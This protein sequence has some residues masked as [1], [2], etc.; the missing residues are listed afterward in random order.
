M[1]EIDRQQF[2]AA[3]DAVP[4]GL[5]PADSKPMYRYHPRSGAA[6]LTT[7]SGHYLPWPTGVSWP[8]TQWPGGCGSHCPDDEAAF[9]YDFGITYGRA[10]WASKTGTVAYVVDHNAA[11]PLSWNPD[12]GYYCSAPGSP[13]NYVVINHSEGAS[14]YL[15][16]KQYSVPDGLVP[17]VTWRRGNRVGESG[18]VG[19]VC[20]STNTPTSGAHLHYQV[21]EH[22]IWWEQ[23]SSVDF[24]DWNETSANPVSANTPEPD[25]TCSAPT[26]APNSLRGSRSSVTSASP[27]NPKAMWLR[28]WPPGR[29]SWC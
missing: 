6:D 9:A 21:Q 12:W 5:L 19:Y 15:H 13:A 23:S 4:V 3:L 26:F 14:L 2:N 25:P 17:G 16:L 8:V 18:N 29:R 20:S 24:A 10:I 7:Y 28:G 11:S 1:A 27:D 22:G